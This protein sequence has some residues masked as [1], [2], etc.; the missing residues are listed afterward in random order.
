MLV[1]LATGCAHQPAP[2][3]NKAAIPAPS[4]PVEAFYGTAEPFAAEA[5]YFVL[6]DRFVNGD[7]SNDHRD[8][9]GAQG[10][11]DRPVKGGPPGRSANIGYLGGDFRGILDNAAYIRDMGFSALWLTPIVDNPDEAFTGGDEVQWGGSFQDRGKT[12]YHG[13]WGVNFYRL[14]EH[15]PSAGLDFAALTAGLDRHGLKTVL[16]IV[17]NHGSPSW[18]MPADQPKYGEIYDAGGALIA[19]HQNLPPGELDPAGNRLH[20]FF[21][22]KPDL[23]QLSNIDDTHPAVMDYFVKAYSQWIDQGADAFRVDT[24]RHMPMPFWKEFSARIRAKRPGFFMFGEAF[25]HK[26]ENIAPH[27]WAENGA[28]SVL[29]FPLKERMAEVFGRKGG[30]FEQL[31]ERLYLTGG[32]YANPYELMTFY[33][34]HDMARLDASDDGFVDAHN[35]LF[36]ARGIPVIYYGSETGFM[37]GT[38]EHAGNRNYFG[39]ERVDAA[40]G[41][42]IREQLKRIARVRAASPALQRGLQLEISMQGDRAAFYRVLQHEGEAQIALVLL[43]KADAPADFEIRDRLQPGIWRAAVGGGEVQVGEGDSLSA[44]VPAHGVEVYLLDAPIIRE[45]LRSALADAMRRTRRAE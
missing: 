21:H 41:H 3:A 28:I 38:A 11:F 30:G 43:N 31:S 18:T 26:A 13:Y 42:P 39:Q 23:V 32:P 4:T 1:A 14:D 34:N 40:V 6:T 17:T 45:D 44:R 36:T 22:T 8:Q 2:T 7:P 15:L 9:G 35:W 19:D 25:D 29:D 33:D 5:V 27:T 24:I 12:G 10:S 20:R 16:D 37:R